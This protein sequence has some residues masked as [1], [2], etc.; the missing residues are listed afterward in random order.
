MFSS[1]YS[2]ILC[3]LGMQKFNKIVIVMDETMKLRLF[4]NL[5]PRVKLRRG[6]D[7]FNFNFK[8]LIKAHNAAHSYI[9]HDYV[10]Y[11]GK[12]WFCSFMASRKI[13]SALK[14]LLCENK[15]EAIACLIEI[16]ILAW[17]HV[18]VDRQQPRLLSKKTKIYAWCMISD[19]RERF[20]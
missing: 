7:G 2:W 15:C 14:L 10:L 20:I 5:Q 13:D 3:S 16:C 12:K 19:V 9:T 18:K 1:F 8:L 11:R 6:L 17:W 4:V